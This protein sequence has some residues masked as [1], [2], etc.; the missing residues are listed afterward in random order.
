[1]NNTCIKHQQIH[2]NE[3]NSVNEISEHKQE[4]YQNSDTSL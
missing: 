1:M 4:L 3:T 2:V